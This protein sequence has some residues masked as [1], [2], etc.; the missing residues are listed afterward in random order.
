MKSWMWQIQM[1]DLIERYANK[2]KEILSMSEYGV[3]KTPTER[4]LIMI[5]TH[6]EGIEKCLVEITKRMKNQ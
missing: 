3:M 2:D 6:L 1:T 4:S 5:A